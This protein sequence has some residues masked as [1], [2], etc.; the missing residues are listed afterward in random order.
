[1]F[2]CVSPEFDFLLFYFDLSFPVFFFSFSLLHFE[3]HTELDNLIAMQ[4][5]RTSANKGSKDAYDVSVSLTSCAN[6]HQNQLRLEA[7][8]V[9]C[10]LGVRSR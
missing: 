6:S 1:M 4:N 10:G 8:L 5:L 9:R 2:M 3:L 7:V